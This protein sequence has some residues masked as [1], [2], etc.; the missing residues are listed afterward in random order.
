MSHLLAHC[1]LD[2]GWRCQPCCGVQT[3]QFALH[4]YFLL[5]V[6]LTLAQSVGCNNTVEHK[7]AGT[8][9]THKSSNF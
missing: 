2:H 3:K 6:V 4:L 8:E 5:G 9:V 1:I 7:A